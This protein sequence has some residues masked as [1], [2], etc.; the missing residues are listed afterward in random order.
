MVWVQ[1]RRGGAANPFYDQTA[2]G[3][4]LE[5][6]YGKPSKLW[7]PWGTYHFAGSGSGRWDALLPKI[8]DRLGASVHSEEVQNHMG[9]FGPVY[10]L[11]KVDDVPLP[12]PMP[13]AKADYVSYGESKAAWQDCAEQ[14]AAS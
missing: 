12:E 1:D 2:D 3:I 14:Y 6:Y 7:T 8:L 4:Y 10:A 9:C 13:R 11:H 5:M